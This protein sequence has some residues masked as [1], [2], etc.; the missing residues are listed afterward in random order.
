MNQVLTR[1]NLRP[2][3]PVRWSPR[4]EHERRVDAVA[5]ELR[6]VAEPSVPVRL[7]KGGVHHLV[8]LP[9]DTRFLGRSV[10]VSALT[11]V[12]EIDTRARLCTAE[13]GATFGEVVRATLEHGL[14]PAVVPELEG[15]TV[16][17]AVAG[18][19]LE[20]T[21]FR[22]GGFH[23]SCVEY[24]LLTGDGELL[25]CSRTREPQLF[26]MVHGSFGTLGI[27]TRLVFELV[28]AA[29]FVSVEYQR[30][31]SVELF[32]S[33]L[34]DACRLDAAGRPDFVDAILHG[35]DAL[36]LCLGRFTERAA[37][38][39]SYGTTGIYYRSTLDRPR[40][41]LTTR[42]Y[43]FR[44]DRDCHWLTESMRSLQRPMVRRLFGRWL[45]GSTNL[46]AWSKRLSPL[47]GFKRRPNV[48][49]DLLLPARRFQ[50]FM[51]WYQDTVSHYPVWVVPYRVPAPYPWISDAH[52]ARM[53]DELFIDCAIYG[54]KNSE[55]GVDYS[56]LIEAKVFELG[57]LKTL[58]SR[59][60]YTRERFWEIY[61][62]PRYEAAKRRL[63]PHHVFG[64]VYDHV[65]TEGRRFERRDEPER[66][67]RR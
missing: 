20:S 2:L 43:C 16:G 10:D 4:Q 6:R 63:D 40:D 38:T 61:D 19:S 52:W 35:P 5:R 31:H 41:T 30:F 9:W 32:E 67:V 22:Q 34:R 47:W 26:E 24:E 64:D 27:L 54:K 8:P 62:R 59:N 28:P 21:S 11:N 36:V 33:A 51:R 13:P 56:K 7:K 48:V 12:L 37:E 50:D 66:S 14:V 65:V 1:A 15:I 25:T 49:V 18:F 60:H 42:E 58:I 57:G 55:P 53:A 29:P 23:D 46:I 45:L 3:W 17:G 44:Y 39:S